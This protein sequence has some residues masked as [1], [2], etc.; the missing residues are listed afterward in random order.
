VRRPHLRFH[1]PPLALTADL[2]WVLVRAFGPP[3]AALPAGFP[4]GS[5]QLVGFNPA[6]TDQPAGLHPAADSDQLAAF[7]PAACHA[8]A[9]RLDVAPRIA[10]RQGRA[11][12]AAELGEAAAGS[13][14][15]DRQAA[16]ANALRL[17]GLARELAAAAAGLALPVVFLKFTALQLAGVVPPG[18]RWA[19]DVDLLVP[20][21]RARELFLALAHAGYRPAPQPEHEHQ[22]PA[23]AHPVAGTVEIHRSIPGLRLA[24]GAPSA[25]AEELAARQLLVP[26]PELPGRCARPNAELLAAH[27]LVHGLAQHGAHPAAYPLLRMVADLVDLGLAGAAGEA[28]ARAAGRLVAADVAAEE[29]A[30]ARELAAALVAGEVPPAASGAGLLLAH[31]V[32]GALDAD[33]RQA[34]RLTLFSPQP[35]DRPR[36]LQLA[37]T[38]WRTLV[39]TRGQIDAVYGRPR[40]AAGYLLRRLARPFDLLLRWRRY[41]ASRRRLARRI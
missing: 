8:L 22:L 1:P 10:H 13:F 15:R 38:L 19:T 37:A 39:P 25:T 6:G 36:A 28:L 20:A 9:V 16:A 33:Y 41:R 4:A 11:A 27:A 12:L 21:E 24:P 31:V 34:Q 3:G 14:H 18:S 40:T 17:A 30:A 29:V 23:L 35:S 5:D 7:D 26:C 32:A 2:A